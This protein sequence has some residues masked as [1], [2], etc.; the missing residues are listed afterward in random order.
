MFGRFPR[1]VCCGIPFPANP[2]FETSLLPSA[3]RSDYFFH[4]VFWFSFYNIRRWVDIIGSVIL[5]FNVRGEEVGMED[6]MYVPVLG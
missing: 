6:V 5:G 1:V 3:S 2:V 4:L